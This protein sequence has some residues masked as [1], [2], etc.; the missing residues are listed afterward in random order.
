[1]LRVSEE[2]EIDGV[3]QINAKS[4]PG[5][6]KFLRV[7]RISLPVKMEMNEDTL[8]NKPTMKLSCNLKDSPK[9]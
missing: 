8:K 3:S 6:S 4:P 9:C 7:E 5:F 1:M 2:L